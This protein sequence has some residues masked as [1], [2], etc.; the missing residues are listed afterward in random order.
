MPHPTMSCIRPPAFIALAAAIAWAATAMLGCAP[1][2][3][4]GDNVSHG[5]AIVSQPK[6]NKVLPQPWGTITWYVSSELGNSETMTV[7]VAVVKPGMENPRHFHPNC[8][9]VLHVIKGSIIHSMDDRKVAMS[10]GDTVSIPAGVH[11]NAKNVGSE[12][13]VLSIC[14]SSAHRQVVGE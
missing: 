14:F 11:H 10:A 2:A 6:D 12:D 8:D 1:D 7:G 13:A 5:P 4:R 9:E 3:P